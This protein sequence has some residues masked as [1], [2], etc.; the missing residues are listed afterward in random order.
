MSRFDPTGQ[1]ILN[2]YP[3]PNYVDPN[4]SKKYRYNFRTRYSGSWPRRQN[5][6]RMDY[7]LS[8]YAEP[9][10]PRDGR[11]QRAAYALG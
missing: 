9:L 5:M 2:F 7:N 8:P 11:L 10:L 4:P 3:L 1:A 6:G